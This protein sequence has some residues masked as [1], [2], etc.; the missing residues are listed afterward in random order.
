MMDRAHEHGLLTALL[1]SSR[2]ALCVAGLKFSYDFDWLF[3]ADPSDLRARPWETLAYFHV[4]PPGMNLFAS[5][6]FAVGAGE[7]G[8]RLFYGAAGVLLVNSLFYLL[9][10]LGIPKLVALVV[11]LVFAMLP[12]TLYFEH[13]FTDT[14]P[15]AALCTLAAAILHRA[16]LRPKV[17][18]WTVFF[19]T[20]ALLCLVRSSFHLVWFA[21]V[22]IGALA[23]VPRESRSIV[24]KSALAPVLVVVFVYGKNLALFGFFAPGSHAGFVAHAL[25]NRVLGSEKASLVSNGQLSPLAMLPVY[26]APR[27][28]EPYFAAPSP[29]LSSLLTARQR[30]TIAAPNY[31]HLLLLDARPIHQADARR[32]VLARPLSYAREA[33][34]T[35]LTF[36][37]P[38]TR[39]HPL[40]GSPKGP[41]HEHRQLLG[42]WETTFDLLIHGFPI[43]PAGLYI[44]LP[45]PLAWTVR[46][47]E[48]TLT[49]GS[50]TT[51]EAGL[52]VFCAIQIC[53]AATI[54][55]L[56]LSTEA[57]RYRYAIEPLAWLVAAVA[58]RHAF[59]RAMPAKSS[60]LS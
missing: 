56:S 57:A 28:F 52:L 55:A 53:Y 38:S 59:A 26:A 7:L 45:L 21:A 23:L 41:H 34:R 46:R 11:S 58:I 2:V 6:L 35:L 49:A 12:S 4:Y 10:S 40:D 47:A 16:L 37:G 14:L 13:S 39:Y 29:A 3:F 8:A 19:S 24:V 54:A 1:V 5:A 17:V 18:T 42:T 32:A 31:N 60:R 30:R 51:A 43:S 20:L 22:F 50:S 25:T 44:L 36:L 9:R 48:R 27:D 33:S 15:S